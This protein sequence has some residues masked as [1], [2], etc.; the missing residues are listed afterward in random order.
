MNTTISIGTR[1]G[2]DQSALGLLDHHV[3]CLGPCEVMC[4][5]ST[6]AAFGPIRDSKATYSLDSRYPC[7]TRDDSLSAAAMYMMYSFSSGMWGRESDQKLCP[8]SLILPNV[9]KVDLNM[10]TPFTWAVLRSG[11]LHCIHL[12]I[13]V[14]INRIAR[15]WVAQCC[16]QLIRF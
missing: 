11:E 3:I 16:N 6:K 5:V 2:S 8:I 1:N 4:L 10:W 9:K 15:H 13:R 14:V 12:D 7:G